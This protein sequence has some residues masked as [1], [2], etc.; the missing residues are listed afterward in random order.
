M[1]RNSEIMYACR[2]LRYVH[3]ITTEEFVNIGIVLYNKDTLYFK[4]RTERIYRLFPKADRDYIIKILPHYGGFITLFNEELPGNGMNIE[5]IFDYILPKDD[6]SLQ[7]SPHII[8]GLTTNHELTF[9]QIFE[10]YITRYE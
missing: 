7:W 3:D 9:L 2:I 6:S 4:Y 1:N 5:Q 8:Q 10:R